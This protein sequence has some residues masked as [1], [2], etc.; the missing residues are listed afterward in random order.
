MKANELRMENLVS[1]DF[2][3]TPAIFK[4]NSVSGNRSTGHYV[5]YPGQVGV[6]KTSKMQPIPL[7]EEWLVKLG[8]EK[9]DSQFTLNK[10]KE[11]FFLLWKFSDMPNYAVFSDWNGHVSIVIDHV[12]QLQNLYFALT[13]KELTIK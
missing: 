3:G 4:L 11:N 12:H 10:G 8:F 13:G 2:C 6:D 1:L 9:S 7:T 5:D